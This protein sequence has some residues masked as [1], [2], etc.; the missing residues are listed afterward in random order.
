MLETPVFEASAPLILGA[1]GMS[2][3]LEEIRTL[4][5]EDQLLN[6]SVNISNAFNTPT[7]TTPEIED[8]TFDGNFEEFITWNGPANTIGDNL[9]SFTD[10]LTADTDFSQP[11]HI[12]GFKTFDDE[13]IEL[14]APPS[15]VEG[16]V[17]KEVD[18]QNLTSN[19]HIETVDENHPELAFQ[20]ENN[21]VLKWII[22]DQRIDDLPILEINSIPLPEDSATREI[23][24]Q[25][26]SLPVK[27]EVKTEDLGEDEKYR[28]MRIQNN[29]SSRKC[30]LNRKRKQQDMEEECKLLEERNVFL[31]SRVEEMEK[32]AKV[33]KQKLL[34]DISSTSHSKYF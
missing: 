7:L 27:K 5:M 21:D 22:D 19:V 13:N 18:E 1:E 26:L 14:C 29:E 4:P 9:E 31:K 11:E 24:V 33:W 30:R 15:I 23:I 25:E 16:N 17:E 2:F 34:S 10:T 20:F 3:L 6:N 28:K 12:W 8:F 32:E